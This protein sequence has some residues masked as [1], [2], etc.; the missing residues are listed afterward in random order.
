M[1]NK[2]L[3]IARGTYRPDR[4]RPQLEGTG[5]IGQVPT[6]VATIPKIH[7]LMWQSICEFLIEQGLLYMHNLW[8]VEALILAQDAYLTALQSDL[9]DTRNL[10]RMNILAGTVRGFAT[11][12]L[13]SPQTMQKIGVAKPSDERDPFE[14]LLYG[15]DH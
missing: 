9:S 12:L 8:M 4:E 2:E 11:Q 6:P 15:R 7:H 13:I 14:D 10:N 1:K 3:K 5:I